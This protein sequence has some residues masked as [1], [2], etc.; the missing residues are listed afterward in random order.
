MSL[1]PAC[2]NSIVSIILLFADGLVFRVAAMK[3]IMSAILIIVGI[4]L[5]GE[6]GV[7]I[8]F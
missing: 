6:I 7:T 2:Y 1:I 8:P 5:P 4:L 3:G